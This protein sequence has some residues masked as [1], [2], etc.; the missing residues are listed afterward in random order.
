MYC[1]CFISLFSS[2]VSRREKVSLGEKIQTKLLILSAV[3][4]LLSLVWCIFCLRIVHT[5]NQ[6]LLS[7]ILWD[8][9]QKSSLSTEIERGSK[10]RV[11]DF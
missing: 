3:G 10:N 5:S 2:K 4:G 6:K 7:N 9:A 8:A 11:I 1:K